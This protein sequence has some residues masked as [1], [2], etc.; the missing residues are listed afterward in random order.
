[1]AYQQP[2]RSFRLQRLLERRLRYLF[3]ALVR[4]GSR[5]HIP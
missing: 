5:S 1:M 2:G 4:K 3:L